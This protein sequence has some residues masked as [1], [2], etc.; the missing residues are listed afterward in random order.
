M[1]RERDMPKANRSLSASQAGAAYV[2]ARGDTY[3]LGRGVS[4][5]GLRDR[6]YDR[7]REALRN[8]GSYMPVLM[9]ACQEDQL[10][11]EYRDG[12]TSQPLKSR[13]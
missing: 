3:R 12:A 5:R 10:S 7:E 2:G 9:E 8:K 6:V 4:L 11:Y 13:V 1:W